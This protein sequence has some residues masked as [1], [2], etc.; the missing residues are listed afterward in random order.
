LPRPDSPSRVVQ[1]AYFISIP[2]S[3]VVKH[4]IGVFYDLF[5]FVIPYKATQYACQT[6]ENKPQTKNTQG[7]LAAFT[8]LLFPRLGL[9]ACQVMP[10]WQNHNIRHSIDAIL[11]GIMIFK[12]RELSKHRE[13]QYSIYFA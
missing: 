13:F 9:Y 3:D 4:R 10:I 6:F 1:I 12:A 5:E 7:R 2:T 8:S 11:T